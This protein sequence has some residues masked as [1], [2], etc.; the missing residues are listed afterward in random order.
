MAS[1]GPPGN[2]YNAVDDSNQAQ[3]T[4]LKLYTTIYLSKINDNYQQY[5]FNFSIAN[6]ALLMYRHRVDNFFN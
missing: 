4:F 1:Q 5:V 6:V 2:N 3:V